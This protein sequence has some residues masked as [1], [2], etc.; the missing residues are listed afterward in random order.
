[1]KVVLEKEIEKIQ[2][3]NSSFILEQIGQV[4]RPC[5]KTVGLWDS[6]KELA[7]A[8]E[9]VMGLVIFTPIAILSWFPFVSEFQSRLLF[10]Q[11]F[12][13]GLQ[14]SM[15]LSGRTDGAFS[16]IRSRPQDSKLTRHWLIPWSPAIDLACLLQLLRHIHLFHTD[17]L[18]CQ[19]IPQETSWMHFKEECI[20]VVWLIV[21]LQ[22][23]K[24]EEGF[25][26]IFTDTRKFEG[27]FHSFGS[28]ILSNWMDSRG[29]PKYKP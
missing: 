21:D 23:L 24:K 6:I 9:Y 13:R 2:V 11:A 27:K 15:I 10:N 17:T 3:T 19:R 28:K 20:W 16:Q 12:S 25:S 18:Q 14:I 4:C 8:Y 1:M 7:R 22:S 26:I 5:L 29:I